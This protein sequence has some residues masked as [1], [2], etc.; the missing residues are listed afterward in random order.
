[1]F[2]CLQLKKKIKGT[3]LPTEYVSNNKN[4]KNSLN[5]IFE[6][7]IV[8]YIFSREQCSCYFFLKLQ[9]DEHAT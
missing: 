8:I 9:A 2:I 4:S 3:L 1:M 5:E 7:L 6:I